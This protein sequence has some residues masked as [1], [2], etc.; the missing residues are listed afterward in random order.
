MDRLRV[1]PGQLTL[2]RLLQE[3]ASAY[4]EIVNLRREIERFDQ[5]VAERA[6]HASLQVEVRRARPRREACAFRSGCARTETYSERRAL[7]GGQ[8]S[9]IR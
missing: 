9:A 2:G 7:L 8:T 5:A 4:E 6:I 3:R 1:D